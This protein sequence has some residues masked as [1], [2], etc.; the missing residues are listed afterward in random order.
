MHVCVDIQARISALEKNVDIHAKISSD[1]LFKLPSFY[2]T[3]Q[4]EGHTAKLKAPILP[5]T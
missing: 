1:S 5:L 4:T 2:G 3:P